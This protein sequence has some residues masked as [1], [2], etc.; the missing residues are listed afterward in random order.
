VPKR[1]LDEIRAAAAK[2]PEAEKAFLFGDHEVFRVRK[3]VFIWLGDNE[4]GGTHISV[5]LKDTHHAALSLPFAEPAAYGMAKWGWIAANFPKG[6]DLP[7]AL[8]LE[9]LEESYRHTAPKKLLKLLDGEVAAKASARPAGK[10]VKA[11]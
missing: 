3:K 8:I 1:G 5:K 6:R 11:R 7:I 4:D 2:Y 10:R 9:W